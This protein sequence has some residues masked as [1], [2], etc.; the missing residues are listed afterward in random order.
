MHMGKYFVVL[1]IRIQKQITYA[2]HAQCI[3]LTERKR[4]GRWSRTGTRGLP[5][6]SLVPSPASAARVSLLAASCRQ[7]QA[8]LPFLCRVH[9][10]SGEQKKAVNALS[11]LLPDYDMARAATQQWVCSIGTKMQQT[12]NTLS[13]TKNGLVMFSKCLPEKLLFGQVKGIRRTPCHRF[14]FNGVALHDCQK[15]CIDSPDKDAQQSALERQGLPCT[16]LAHHKLDSQQIN[17]W[18]L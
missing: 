11:P 18:W 13:T 15:F 17:A 14:S 7:S 16:Y 10:P 8:C 9:L 1:D 6:G 3:K 12:C 5:L 4:G 2:L